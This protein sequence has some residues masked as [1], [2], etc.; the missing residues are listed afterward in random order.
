MLGTN[1]SDIYRVATAFEGDKEFRTVEPDAAAATRELGRARFYDALAGR[2]GLPGTAFTQ[3]DA[4][5]EAAQAPGSTPVSDLAVAD[6]LD[7]SRMTVDQVIDLADMLR[8]SGRLTDEP[9]DLLSYRLDGLSYGSESVFSRSPVA[10]FA[11][12]L[13]SGGGNR[14]V[15][16]IAQQEEQL[17]YLTENDADPKAIRGARSVLSQLR[18][19]QLEQALYAQIDAG[20]DRSDDAAGGFGPFSAATDLISLPPSAL[21]L[22][23]TT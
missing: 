18:Q 11:R 15:D 23:A 12:S 4:V 8:G 14:T 20:R 6:T 19:L 16:L 7:L 21:S 5:A 13:S 1:N 17:R 2:Y 3:A 9:A 22:F 10:D